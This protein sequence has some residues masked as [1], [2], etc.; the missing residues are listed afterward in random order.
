VDQELAAERLNAAFPGW[1]FT[2][3]IH[4][5]HVTVRAY[6]WTG[7]DPAQV[8]AIVDGTSPPEP[9][10]VKRLRH[11]EPWERA[12]WEAMLDLVN[13]ARPV[14]VTFAQFRQLARD[15]L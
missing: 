2:L 6:D 1:A 9:R 12:L 13:E 7:V 14:P 5:Q 15:R 4:D 10:D 11:L 8:E 3:R